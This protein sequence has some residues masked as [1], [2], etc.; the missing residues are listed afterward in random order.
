MEGGQ[1][2]IWIE[3]WDERGQRHVLIVENKVG[4]REGRG[5]D[6]GGQLE[7]YWNELRAQDATTQTLVYI[8][9]ASAD[10]PEVGDVVHLRWF[11]IH[12]WLKEW[13]RIKATKTVGC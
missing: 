8:T 9:H 2:D 1:P 10:P 7:R 3:A 5:V 11:E 4:A 6:G 12:E 13:L